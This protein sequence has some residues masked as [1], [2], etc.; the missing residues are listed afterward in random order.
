MNFNC[1]IL[2][3]SAFA[4]AAASA[5]ACSVCIAHALGSAIHSIGAQTLH[6][7]GTVVG[8]SFTTFNKSQDGEE[9]DTTESHRQSEYDIRFLH[10]LNEQ[11]MLR[12]DVPYIFK[13][14][15]MT[16][17]EPTDTKGLGDITLGA[18]YQVKPRVGDKVLFAATFDLKLPTGANN[19]K[20][21][22]GERLEEHSQ[23]G[24]GST[25]FSIGVLA[26]SELK[27]G[28]LVFGGLRARFNGENGEGYRYGNVLF[29]NLGYSHKL[30]EKGSI[31][32]E[33]NGRIASKDKP[34]GGGS[35]ENSGGHFGYLS[36]SYRQSYG[37]DLGFVGTYQIPVIRSL[38]GSQSESGLLTIGVFK[39]L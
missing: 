27:S 18:T 17:E 6:K 15:S 33:L 32:F 10:G 19:L 26:T 29:Y 2:M 5:N 24:T 21:G 28:N 3:I 25:D 36:L 13:R 11:W 39:K 37:K 30:S 34:E 38:N 9:P 35:D 22:D 31:V 8:I 20:D 4:V 16:D 7:G 12:A 23:I 1:R 14:L